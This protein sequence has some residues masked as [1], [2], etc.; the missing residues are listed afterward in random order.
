M[1]VR[2]RFAPSPTGDLHIGS[3][4]TAL[5]AWLFARHHAG[6]F[7]LRIEDTDRERSTRAAVDA[8]E[9]GLQWLGLDADEGPVYQTARFDRYREV[10]ER[11]LDEG[12][13]YYCYCTREEIDA[14]RAAA[15]AKG[16]KPRYDGRCRERRDARDGVQPVVRFKSPTSGRIVVEDKVKGRIEFDNSELDDLIIARSD[17][18]PT[19]NFT[20]V[21]DDGD[22]GITHVIRGDDHVNNTPRQIN[23]FRALGIEPPV[24]AHLPMIHGPDGAKLSKR[25]GAVNVLE[26]RRIGFLPS[27]ML[28]Y[29]A[30]LGWSHGDREIFSVAELIESFDLDRVSR[31]AANFDP[32]KLLWVNHRHIQRTPT[33]ELAALLAGQLERRGLDPKNGPPLETA[34]DALRERSQT[35]LEMAEHAHCYFEELEAFDAKSAKAHLRPVARE[36][37]AAVR[38]A[39]AALTEWT[40]AS[41]DGAVE[42]VSERLGLKLGKVAQPLRVAL[43]GR[44][45]SPGIGTTLV[46]VGRERA[47]CRIGRALD[48]VDAR[49]ADTE[50]R[51][52]D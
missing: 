33:A 22:M 28:N 2:T 44:A 46:L 19:Y 26:Y 12:K 16:L 41:T 42:A 13:A 51:G 32:A 43:T 21:V 9:E 23:L 35:M 4:R 30:R 27:A 7:I 50:T 45:A 11:L 17:G 40:E 48:Y 15:E 29:L 38:E 36:A 37:L 5:Y 39:L 18:T 49:A 47:L 52:R 25:H 14:M 24:F 8:I 31:S 6:R 20:V 10:V 1:T 3:V 34:V